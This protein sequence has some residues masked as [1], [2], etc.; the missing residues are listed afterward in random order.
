[1]MEQLKTSN[2]VNRKDAFIN[3]HFKIIHFIVYGPATWSVANYGFVLT[4]FEGLTLDIYF[5]KR[6]LVIRVLDKKI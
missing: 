4:T 6:L 2:H 3:L 1:M 5:G